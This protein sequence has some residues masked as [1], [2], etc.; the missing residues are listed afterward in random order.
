MTPRA[1][2]KPAD[3]RLKWLLAVGTTLLCLLGLELGARG[4]RALATRGQKN[5]PPHIVTDTPVLYE[6]NPEHPEVSS[7]GLRDDEVVIPKPDGTLRLLV[8]GDSVAYGPEVPRAAAFP[9]LL[10]TS[11]R[12]R[13]GSVEVINVGV[14]GYSPYNQLHFYLGKGRRFEPDIVIVAFCMNDVANPRL[15]WN[16][17]GRHVE[18]IP[19]EA[20]P[21]HEYDRNHAAPSLASWETGSDPPSLLRHSELYRLLAPRGLSSFEGDPAPESVPESRI[22][23]HITGED[24]LSIEV[25]VD[26]STPEWSWLT[27]MYDRLHTAVEADQAKM[28]IVFFPL[29]YQLDASYPFLPQKNLLRYCRD[30]SIP[31]LDMLE[32]LRRH[33]PRQVFLMDSAGYHDIWHLTRFGHELTAGAL[34]RFLQNT[35]LLSR[36]PQARPGSGHR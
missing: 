29:A 30:R 28:I 12:Q 15:H 13:Y 1:G 35:G 22:P 19:P 33:R 8:L 10:E 7:Q 31:C 32:P 11:L 34:S 4:L 14:P 26:E 5:V 27:S 2:E 36:H 21:N 16:R 25:L 20:I 24:T 6:M 9:D 18:V 23:T 17:A 3:P